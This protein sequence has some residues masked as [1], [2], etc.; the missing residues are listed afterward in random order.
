MDIVL[1]L[2]AAGQ[3]AILPFLDSGAFEDPFENFRFIAYDLHPPPLR[4]TSLEILVAI[5]PFEP[6]VDELLDGANGPVGEFVKHRPVL[7]LR[8]NARRTSR[9]LR[10]DFDYILQCRPDGWVLDVAEDGFDRLHIPG[11][12]AASLLHRRPTYYNS[13]TQMRS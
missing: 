10:G 12:R 7:L 1:R 6:V 3:F 4:V 5:L 8:G 2:E 11:A 13:H 9:F